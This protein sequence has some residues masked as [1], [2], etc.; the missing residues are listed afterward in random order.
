MPATRRAPA[1]LIILLLA[2]CTSGAPGAAPTS[3]AAE[4]TVTPGATLPGGLES[5]M[6]RPALVDGEA[7]AC[8]P[9]CAVGRVEGGMLPVGRYQTEWFFGGYMTLETDGSWDRG[10]DSN[11]E[12]GL[13]IAAPEGIGVYQVA[14]S[15][16]PSLVVGDIVQTEIPR[17]TADYVEWLGTQPEL[18]VSE[19][20][21]AR[22]GSVPAV[23]VDIRLGPNA[24]SQYDDCPPDPCVTF[25]KVEAFDHSDGILGDDEY[26]FYFAD[27]TYSGA[28]HMLVVKV[29]GRDPEDLD[30]V[31][32]KV[33]ALLETVVI[34]ARPAPPALPA[35]VGDW[36]G[37]H[38]CQRIVDLM[39]AAGMPEQAL[40]N[41]AE[42]GTIPDVTTIADIADPTNPC[43]GAVDKEHSHFFTS[44]GLF[45]SRDMNGQQ[46]DDGAWVLVDADTFTINGT[47]FDFQVDGDEL[48]MEPV[49]VGTCPVNG[50]WCPEAWKLMVAMPGMAWTRDD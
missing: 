20:I 22:I 14:F 30:A 18:I 13:P 49:D 50:Q 11:G 29:E 9:G 5:R 40:L 45:G 10:E 19:P 1:A 38:N 12:L 48:R 31:L 43:L 26:R 16:D 32:P 46:V 36:I 47:P 42:S 2:A 34:P 39:N 33:E 7:A 23:A 25:I 28:D 8:I 6:G 37:F 15:L 24:P 21:D 3:P 35:L 4:P 17:Q 44:G 27:I 41:A